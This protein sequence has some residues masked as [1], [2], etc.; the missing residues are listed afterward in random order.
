MQS[1]KAIYFVETHHE[2][3]RGMAGVALQIPCGGK[4]IVNDSDRSWY[5]V[6]GISTSTCALEGKVN[7]QSMSCVGHLRDSP[8][9]YLITVMLG[10][11]G[12]S[13]SSAS[14]K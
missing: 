9:P 13:V 5:T 10:W 1:L 11:A 6:T 3:A 14:S 7:P 12:C 2:E 8:S 4:P